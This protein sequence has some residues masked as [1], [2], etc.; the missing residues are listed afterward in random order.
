MEGETAIHT[1]AEQ[2]LPLNGWVYSRFPPCPPSFA[3]KGLNKSRL[4]RTQDHDTPTTIFQFRPNRQTAG[5]HPDTGYV[6]EL[7]EMLQ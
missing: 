4:G 5:P 2:S 7:L 3:V 1:I 6:E